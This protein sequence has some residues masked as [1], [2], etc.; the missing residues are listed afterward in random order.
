LAVL[1][2]NVLSGL[3]G[4]ALPPEFLTVKPKRLWFF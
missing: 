4:L 2:Y 3:K 1:A